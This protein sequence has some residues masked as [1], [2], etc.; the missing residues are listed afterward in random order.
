MARMCSGAGTR[1]AAADQA[2]RMRPPSRRGVGRSG[3]LWL[4]GHSKRK[5]SRSSSPIACPCP[6]SSSSQGSAYSSAAEERMLRMTRRPAPGPSRARPEP[7]RPKAGS[8]A[9][10]PPPVAAAQR[11]APAAGSPLGP[12]SALSSM[13]SG[14]WASRL[15]RSAG[16][17]PAARGGRQTDHS[18]PWLAEAAA[19]PAAPPLADSTP[20]CMVCKKALR[21]QSCMLPVAQTAPWPT[22]GGQKRCPL[23]LRRSPSGR[24]AISSGGPSRTYGPSS[25]C[26]LSS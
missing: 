5:S 7:S 10:S 12:R 26:R 14:R 18:T 20:H 8:A 1:P 13:G 16:C 9:A 11:P 22:R 24:S 6:R 3:V 19:G 23:L 15:R 25:E 4:S 21:G 2:K 17:I